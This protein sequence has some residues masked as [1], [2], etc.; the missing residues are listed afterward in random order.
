MS[1]RKPAAKKPWTHSLVDK[2]ALIAENE[3]NHRLAN[4]ERFA[5]AIAKLEDNLICSLRTVRLD[6][7]NGVKEVVS[8]LSRVESALL[9][10]ES[11]QRV[12]NICME[13][14][15]KDTKS[16]ADAVIKEVG[17]LL[18]DIRQNAIY[19]GPR[20]LLK[21][22]V[23]VEK[24]GAWLPGVVVG[25]QDYERRHVR[26]DNGTELCVHQTRTRPE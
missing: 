11:H 6:A 19:L 10:L 22:R 8:L 9:N 3:E 26:L 5:A 13:K 25:V 20:P 18:R 2:L 14:S 16:I 15:A 12:S 23:L 7:A 21:E 24:D 4:A 1:K 17:V